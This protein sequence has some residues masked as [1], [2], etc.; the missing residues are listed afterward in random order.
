MVISREVPADSAVGA[1]AMRY[2]SSQA[3]RLTRRSTSSLTQQP[4]RWSFTIPTACMNGVHR[5]RADEAP[6]AAAQLLAQRG[7]FGRTRERPQGG[8]IEPLG[9]RRRV[10]RRSATRRPRASLPPPAARSPAGVVEHRFDLA[11]VAD[12]AGVAEQA[13]DVG[14][15]EARDRL[16]VE[17]GEGAAEVLALAQDR[18]PGQARLEALEAELLEQVAV[19]GRGAA[20]LVVVV[21]R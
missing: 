3:P 8:P 1:D 17:V 6:A 12:D 5:R 10:R 14:G 13:L 4:S 19:V 18:Q 15:A 11:A 9:P 2:V 7:R 21:G 16:G 20:P